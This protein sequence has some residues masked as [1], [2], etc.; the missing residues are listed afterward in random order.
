MGKV[1]RDPIFGRDTNVSKS[2]FY[3]IIKHYYGHRSSI[4]HIL[5]DC[6]AIDLM[7]VLSKSL[8]M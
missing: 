4:F 1:N 5:I 3:Y 6:N 2:L 7:F 8:E